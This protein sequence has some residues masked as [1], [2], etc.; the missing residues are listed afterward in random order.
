VTQ[1]LVITPLGD[2]QLSENGD[3]KTTDNYNFSIIRRLS[4]TTPGYARFIEDADGVREI[5]IQYGSD[6]YNFLSDPMTEVSEELLSD[7]VKRS[8]DFDPRIA[9]LSVERE[10]PS[11][12]SIAITIRYRDLETGA[13]SV[14]TVGSLG[15]ENV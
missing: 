2:I 7:T 13:I 4:T 6:L 10:L 14:A 3:L 12:N 9:I 8:L 15:T 11:Q 1:D 5:D